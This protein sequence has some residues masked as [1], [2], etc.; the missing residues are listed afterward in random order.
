MIADENETAPGLCQ[1]YDDPVFSLLQD[2][3]N[4]QQDLFCLKKQLH[5]Y[6]ED[7]LCFRLHANTNP[8]LIKA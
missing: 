8:Q 4:I 7:V 1:A 2:Y 6:V 3:V 5:R